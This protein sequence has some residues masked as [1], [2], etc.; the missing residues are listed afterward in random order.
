MHKKNIK[1][2]KTAKS[3]LILSIPS[4]KFIL[5]LFIIIISEKNRGVTKLL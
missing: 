3:R 2:I 4:V 5:K 1:A